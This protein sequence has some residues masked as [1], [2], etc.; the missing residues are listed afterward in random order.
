M[1]VK[2]FTFTTSGATFLVGNHKIAGRA[3]GAVGSVNGDFIGSATV[4]STAEV[5]LDDVKGQGFTLATS[6]GTAQLLFHT[7]GMH[8]QTKTTMV[9]LM[10]PTQLSVSQHLCLWA[11]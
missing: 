1:A 11:L 2:Y 7:Y 8:L 6:A 9:K 10:L 5:D 3:T 4:A